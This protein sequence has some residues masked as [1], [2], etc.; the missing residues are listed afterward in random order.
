MNKNW[1][2]EQSDEIF[3]KRETKLNKT[4]MNNKGRQIGYEARQKVTKLDKTETSSTKSKDEDRQKWDE[5]RRADE[6]WQNKVK[7]R[8]LKR[9]STKERQS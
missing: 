1:S 5:A 8:K 4:E 3:Q 7:G 9:K 2:S 6:A